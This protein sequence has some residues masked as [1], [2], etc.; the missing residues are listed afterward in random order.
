[1][2][3]YQEQE[4][5]KTKLLVGGTIVGAI[6]GLAT[7]FMLARAAEENGEVIHPILIRWTRSKLELASLAQHAQLLHWQTRISCTEFGRFRRT[8]VR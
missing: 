1:M 8:V 5:W 6:I 7:A 4:N 3:N 2:A